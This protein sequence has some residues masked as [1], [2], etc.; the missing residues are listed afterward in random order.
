MSKMKNFIL[1]TTSESGDDYTYYIEHPT[2]PEYS[3]IVDFLAKHC[4]DKCD[5]EKII[6]EKSYYIEEMESFTKIPEK[7]GSYKLLGH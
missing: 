3:E 2:E 7:D 1:T 4:S 5:E 6:Y